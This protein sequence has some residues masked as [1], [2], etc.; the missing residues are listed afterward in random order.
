MTFSIQQW[1]ANNQTCVTCNLGGGSIMSWA[2][3]TTSTKMDGMYFA[4]KKHSV[5]ILKKL[6]IYVDILFLNVFSQSSCFF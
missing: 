5:F 6:T 4:L 3:A 1:K 2:A